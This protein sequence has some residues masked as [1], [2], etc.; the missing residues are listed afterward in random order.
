VAPSSPSSDNLSPLKPSRKPAKILSKRYKNRKLKKVDKLLLQVG[1]TYPDLQEYYGSATSGSTTT[2]PS[3]RTVIAKMPRKVSQM[4]ARSLLKEMDNVEV[5]IAS[6]RQVEKFR[7]TRPFNEWKVVLQKGG[8]IVEEEFDPKN[9]NYKLLQSGVY[10]VAHSDVIGK[11]NYEFKYLESLGEE[12]L[13]T[14]EPIKKTIVFIGDYGQS[15]LSF[16]FFLPANFKS[17]SRKNF[18]PLLYLR[19]PDCKSRDNFLKYGERVIKEINSFLESPLH[20]GLLGGDWEW[21]NSVNG[22]MG[23]SARYACPICTDNLKEDINEK[24]KNLLEEK[25]ALTRGSMFRSYKEHKTNAE[26][27]LNFREDIYK[28]KENEKYDKAWYDFHQTSQAK[29]YV[30]YSAINLPIFP[31]LF[32]NVVPFPL[33]VFM[34]LGNHYLK[35][36]H[37]KLDDNKKKEFIQITNA[38]EHTP[39]GSNHQDKPSSFNDWNGREIKNIFDSKKLDPLAFGVTDPSWRDSFRMVT[40]RL[41]MLI[42]YLLSTKDDYLLNDA[43]IRTFTTIINTVSQWWFPVKAAGR[44]KQTGN[45]VEKKEVVKPKIHML[46]HMPEFVKKYKTLGRFSES[47]IESH[48]GDVSTRWARNYSHFGKNEI[49][50]LYYTAKS[51][52]VDRD[53]DIR[54]KHNEKELKNYIDNLNNVNSNNEEEEESRSLTANA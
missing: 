49:A 40:L 38:F 26:K 24:N 43:K 17:A 2:P 54:L 11:I 21:V 45:N 51:I 12:Y 10:G 46:S 22:L 28:K 53:N 13:K 30:S 44:G 52:G 20:I 6:N 47:G 3:P 34:G 4:Q 8:K 23:C 36:L 5:K 32:E 29:P 1:V 16:G 19:G 50:K 9:K 7:K 14:V 35:S 42:P 33:H 48:H 41:R 15:V 25:S 31:L 27:F 18:Q 37:G 39:S